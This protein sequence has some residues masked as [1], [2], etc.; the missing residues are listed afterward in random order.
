[1][2]FWLKL[3]I[4]S[5]VL[6][7]FKPAFPEMQQ[8]KAQIDELDKQIEREVATIKASIRAEYQAAQRRNQAVLEQVQQPLALIGQAKA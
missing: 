2:F 5:S 3:F 1:M 4:S 8:L 7:V 6:S